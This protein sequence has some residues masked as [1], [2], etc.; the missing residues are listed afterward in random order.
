MVRTGD[1]WIPRCAGFGAILVVFLLLLLLVGEDASYLALPFRVTPLN[2]ARADLKR[3]EG[4]WVDSDGDPVAMVIG[5]TEPRLGIRLPLAE[6][7]YSVENARWQEG[8]LVFDVLR[9]DG[10]VPI[11]LVL[12]EVGEGRIVLNIFGPASAGPPRFMCFAGSF[13]PFGVLVPEPPRLW[14]F[15]RA[16]LITIRSVQ[17]TCEDIVSGTFGWL[18]QRL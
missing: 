17:E 10:T 5:G 3:F 7:F 15:K 9:D 2:G 14:Y 11:S 4:R 16:V 13:L 8:D 6:P 18:A 12:H 1:T